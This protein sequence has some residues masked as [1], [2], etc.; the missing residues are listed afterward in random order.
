MGKPLLCLGGL[1]KGISVFAGPIGW[2]ITAIWAAFDMASPAYRVTVPC[3]VQ[4]AYMRQKMKA[5]QA[6]KCD[7]CGTPIGKG[8]KYC[9]ECGKKVPAHS[10]PKLKQSEEQADSY[11]SRI[12]SLWGAF[13]PWG[14]LIAQTQ[15]FSYDLWEA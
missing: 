5:A 4:V 13:D 2:A 14:N 9:S 12:S 7:K 15:P 1:M 10:K 11:T 3:V 6:P 8:I